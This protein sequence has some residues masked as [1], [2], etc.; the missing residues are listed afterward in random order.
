MPSKRPRREAAR[1]ELGEPEGH[2]VLLIEADD[3]TAS[4]LT[5]ILVAEGYL[6]QREI[7]GARGA[8]RARSGA[9]DLLV[10]AKQLPDM[11][12]SEVMARLRSAKVSLPMFLLSVL[13]A[14]GDQGA[15]MRLSAVP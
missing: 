12:G 1:I 13:P 7:L 10:V 4:S 14:A 3:I 15:A 11:T 5:L 6:V 9:Y 2:R 8:E